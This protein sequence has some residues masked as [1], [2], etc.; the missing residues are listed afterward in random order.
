MAYQLCLSVSRTISEGADRIAVCL[1]ALDS[2]RLWT[3]FA[4]NLSSPGNLVL[5][6][7][8]NLSQYV[9]RTLG[10]KP[11]HRDR[12]KEFAGKDVSPS[13]EAASATTCS[14]FLACDTPAPSVARV[15]ASV[16]SLLAGAALA[17]DRRRFGAEGMAHPD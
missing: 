8:G 17:R 3:D 9:A 15:L 12:A 11:F 4:P 14:Q 10:G 1:D 6:L 16:R 13:V 7:I 2:Q 5:H